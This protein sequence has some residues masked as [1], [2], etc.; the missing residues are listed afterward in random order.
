VKASDHKKPPMPKTPAP[1][2]MGQ[3]PGPKSPFANAKVG[4]IINMKPKGGPNNTRKPYLPMSNRANKTFRSRLNENVNAYMVLNSLQ[5]FSSPTIQKGKKS[6][7]SR[8]QVKQELTRLKNQKAREQNEKAKQELNTAAQK[9]EAEL[10]ELAKKPNNATK[11]SFMNK[12][13]GRYNTLKQSVNKYA[14][15]IYK[16]YQQSER[17]M[18]LDA[19]NE[20]WFEE[21]QL[22]NSPYNMAYKYRQIAKKMG[23][24][25]EPIGKIYENLKASGIEDPL[26][27]MDHLEVEDAAQVL[28]IPVELL[29]TILKEKGELWKYSE[30]GFLRELTKRA[31]V[32]DK[33]GEVFVREEVEKM[34]AE[35]EQAKKDWERRQRESSS[36]SSNAAGL[37]LTAAW[38]F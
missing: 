37:A 33:K 38:S 14:K 5:K 12:L 20:K 22:G 29:D 3:T 32:Q 19:E 2:A 36:A 23:R 11:K 34:K 17:N 13:K 30:K 16:Q 24:Q 21:K 35:S 4:N 25:N 10:Q 1:V 15:N 27:H 7:F 18:K 9:V 28:G 8:N 31:L 26:K 6:Y